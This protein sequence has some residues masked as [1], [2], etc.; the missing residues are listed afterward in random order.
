MFARPFT[1]DGE[2]V[3]PVPWRARNA[4]RVPEGSRETVIGEEGKPQGCQCAIKIIGLRY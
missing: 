1:A 3:C 4:T 2:M